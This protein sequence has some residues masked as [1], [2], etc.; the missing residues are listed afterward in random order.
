MTAQQIS[1]Q[2]LS[3]AV[4]GSILKDNQKPLGSRIHA[5]LQT[6]RAAQSSGRFNRRLPTWASPERAPSRSTNLSARSSSGSERTRS[7]GLPPVTARPRAE[8]VTP[9]R[10]TAVSRGGGGRGGDGLPSPQ[11]HP[12]PRKSTRAP[13][14]PLDTARLAR[15]LPPPGSGGPPA[16]PRRAPPLP[17]AAGPGR[18][19]RPRSARRRLARRW[20]AGRAC[21]RAARGPRPEAA[22]GVRRRARARGVPVPRARVCPRPAAARAGRRRRGAVR[23]GM[24]PPPPRR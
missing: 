13:G 15:V 21:A 1:A 5:L 2:N 12:T 23:P 6:G 3:Q 17:L 10:T 24:G 14:A 19:W 8:D 20:S 18:R 16:P 9:A 4:S 22:R 7:A 11:S